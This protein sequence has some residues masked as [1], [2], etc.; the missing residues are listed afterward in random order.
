MTRVRLR[1]RQLQAFSVSGCKGL[2]GVRLEARQLGTLTME[3]CDE[4]GCV[5]L[6][7]IGVKALS[8]GEL[9]HPEEGV[10]VG[11]L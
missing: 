3:R 8:L 10:R 4:L 9:E 11:T 1:H 5:E 2:S 7:G 6:K